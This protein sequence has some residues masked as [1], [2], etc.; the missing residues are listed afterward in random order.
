M[1]LLALAGS[2]LLE[3]QGS[4]RGAGLGGLYLEDPAAGPQLEAQ[5]QC[6]Q[7]V[8]ERL[9]DR[10]IAAQLLQ[11]GSQSNLFSLVWHIVQAGAWTIGG[12]G[13]LRPGRAGVF[14]PP[15]GRFDTRVDGYPTLNGQEIHPQ[16]YAGPV[17]WP[18]SW[19]RPETE[20]KTRKPRT[21]RPPCARSWPMTTS[22]YGGSSA[23]RCS[24]PTSR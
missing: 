2:Q 22:W 4:L 3:Q 15:P 11:A 20:W 12:E 13:G 21:K 6:A 24:A 19:W 18:M 10:L 9:V 7:E 16:G 17:P 14:F 1:D 23:T 5:C 8:L